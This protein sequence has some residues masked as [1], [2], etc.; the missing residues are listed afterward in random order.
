MGVYEEIPSIDTALECALEW[1]EVYGRGKYYARP[2]SL[3]NARSAFTNLGV[4]ISLPKM[5]VER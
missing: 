2:L 5:K 3:G 4:K 1:S